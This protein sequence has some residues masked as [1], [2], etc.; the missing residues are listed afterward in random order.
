MALLI[1]CHGSHKHK[2]DHRPGHDE[3][4]HKESNEVLIS[5][6][7][8]K[9][10]DL[11]SKIYYENGVLNLE[12]IKSELSK[13]DIIK[14]ISEYEH[15]K[16]HHDEHHETEEEEELSF[17]GKLIERLFPSSN[18][19]I[20]SI[21]GVVYIFL[22]S[23]LIIYFIPKNV[24]S[25]NA[26]ILKNLISF[27]CGGILGDV[28]I[29]LLPEIFS[30][31]NNERKNSILGLTVFIGFLIFLIVDKSVRILSGSEHGHSHSHSH[32]PEEEHSHNHSHS[33]SHNHSHSHSH[34]HA[35][36]VE[37]EIE[38]K[39]GELTHRNYKNE[40]E[41]EIEKEIQKL[42]DNF[43]DSNNDSDHIKNS[44][45]K[46]SILV[47]LI[48]C[49]N[50]NISDGMAITSSF[51]INKNIGITTFLAILI[52]EIPHSIS[53]LFLFI[54][55]DNQ[56]SQNNQ[57]NKLKLVKNQLIVFVGSVVGCLIGIFL[58]N[59]DKT[60]SL[61]SNELVNYQ[62]IT[63]SSDQSPNA[64]TGAHNNLVISLLNKF[65]LSKI[66]G[67]F[68]LLKSS[69]DLEISELLLPITVGCFFYISTIGIIPEILE[70]D[71]KLIENKDDDELR[72][73]EICSSIGQ[74]VSMFLGLF[75]MF[76]LAWFE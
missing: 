4:Y 68:G 63:E 6:E 62:S 9:N 48:V 40:D 43:K 47:N 20:N 17:I 29:H 36:G 1:E 16:K 75:V 56:S 70:I 30:S 21:L 10:K 11:V 57:S 44:S 28:F 45:K 25:M 73:R 66:T 34:S 15:K 60:L 53:D 26:T 13:C 24:E 59:F 65:V 14:A 51:Y 18:P 69:L 37:A 52:H 7:F 41:I 46:T 2:H 3:K 61:I 72:R 27:S 42:H 23:F 67:V 71:R 12:Y 35:S 55:F 76:L 50:H 33:H 31:N 19:G 58:Q 74:F 38:E 8:V 39:T 32:G 49:F 54:K 64:S 22:P 5:K